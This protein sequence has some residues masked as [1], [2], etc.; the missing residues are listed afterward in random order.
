VVGVVGVVVA[1][2]VVVYIYPL[3]SGPAAPYLLVLIASPLH[4][5]ACISSR[6]S[7]LSL[8]LCT[9]VHTMVCTMV[10]CVLLY[11]YCVVVVVVVV[12]VVWYWSTVLPYSSTGTMV[13]Y[14]LVCH[15]IIGT[16]TIVWYY[17]HIHTN[18][19]GV[20]A[21]TTGTECL[22]FKLFWRSC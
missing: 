21:R 14:Q 4:L 20:P 3:F 10:L 9:M 2:M 19:T 18:G 1:A 13:W 12:V 5:S 15:T 11:V 16:G 17:G 8:L 22:Y 7:F 6:F